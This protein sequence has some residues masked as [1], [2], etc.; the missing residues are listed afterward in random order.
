MVSSIH[1]LELEKKEILSNS[2]ITENN[3]DELDKF[4]SNIQNNIQSESVSVIE[5]EFEKQTK[6]F[7]LIKFI[8]NLKLGIKTC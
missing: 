6:V 2:N 1:A 7:C 3:E 5:K 8:I 4:M